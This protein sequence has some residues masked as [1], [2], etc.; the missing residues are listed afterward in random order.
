[1]LVNCLKIKQE[2]IEIM[3]QIDVNTECDVNLQKLADDW[4]KATLNADTRFYLSNIIRKDILR[5]NVKKWVVT[6]ST[7]AYVNRRTNDANNIISVEAP[8]ATLK[9]MLKVLMLELTCVKG[10]KN[11]NLVVIGGVNNFLRMQAVSDIKNEA[12]MFKN[13]V[14]SFNPNI[15]LNFAAIPLIPQL[16]KL[17]L[18]LHTVQKDRTLE[19]LNYNSYVTTVLNETNVL[20]SM[21][22][23]GIEKPVSSF[24][25]FDHS[26]TTKLGKR[27]IPEQWSEKNMSMGVHL[28]PDIKK[29]FWDT[30]IK[31][32]FGI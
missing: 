15:V 19:F 23:L 2:K 12:L 11:V 24:D 1:M 7:M 30:Q 13:T 18:D 28:K 6:S 21:E 27:H 26:S 10:M 32:F 31:P 17:P 3:D 20:L 9:E 16:C 22:S 25:T 8:G 5:D 4:E 14:K 29:F